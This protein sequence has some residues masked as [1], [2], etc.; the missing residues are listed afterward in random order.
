MISGDERLVTSPDDGYP[1][2][3]VAA[4]ALATLAVPLISLIVALVLVGGQRNER[5]RAQL[6]LWAWASGG[7]MVLWIVVAIG[8]VAVAGGSGVDEGGVV[9]VVP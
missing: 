4:A 5:K 6:R 1:G 3:S 9:T 7:L 2:T 8:L